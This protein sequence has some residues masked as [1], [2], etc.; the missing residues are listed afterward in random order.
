MR[1]GL[2]TFF[3]A[4]ASVCL[5]GIPNFVFAATMGSLAPHDASPSRNGLPSEQWI[6]DPGT[7]CIAADPTYDPGDSISWLGRCKQNGTIYGPGTLSFLYR[8][9]AVETVTGN[10]MDGLLQ[11]GHVLAAWSDGAKYEGDQ[12]GGLFNGEGKFVSAKGDTLE[13]QW[14]MGVLN[15]TASVVWAN[16]DRYDGAWKN[17]KSDGHGIETW[18]DGRR[19]E[20]E[21]RDGMPVS[22]PQANAMHA[23]S[24]AGPESTNPPIGKAVADSAAL[25]QTARQPAFRLA[26]MT[27]AVPRPLVTPGGSTKAEGAEAAGND[28]PNPAL[29]LRTHLGT[30]LVAVDSATL[31][32]ALSEGG[33]ERTVVLPSGNSQE[34]EFVF[35]KGPVGTVSDGEAAIGVFRAKADGLDID[36]ADGTTESIGEAAND[37]VLDRAHSPDGRVMCTAWYPQGHVFS[38]GEKQA[39]VQEYAT[40]LGVSVA[41]SAG[42]HKSHDPGPAC[43]GAFIASGSHQKSAAAA[44]RDKA[45][46][47]P[48]TEP[49]GSGQPAESADGGPA[50]RTGSA[51]GGIA[52]GTSPVHTIDAPGVGPAHLEQ[53]SFAPGV[54]FQATG[55]IHAGSNMPVAQPG[56]SD[57]LMITSNGEYWGFQN[58]CGKS[59]QF[60]YC[61]MSDANPLTACKRTSVS[62]SVASNGFSALVSD[63]SL[64]EKDTEHE[65]RWMACDGGAGEVVPHLDKVDPP[66]GRCE[67]AVAPA[68]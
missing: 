55:D 8:G 38:R 13:G 18:A 57:C 68:D 2:N 6:G 48:D 43:G 25:A 62:G 37:G 12:L 42:K 51:A 9:E 19:F 17:G 67:R 35:A 53:A 5:L 60:A 23:S 26:S 27:P 54:P 34:T 7:K 45:T 56:A 36:Y 49:G 11:P 64:A 65:F 61:E 31:E 20:G 4:A 14:K 15:G 41:A 50:K 66:S 33:F 46:A 47:A 22:N 1:S 40:R 58:R 21:W 39:A 16:G 29:P 63:R 28:A 32:L 59:V 52:V 30:Q 10:F 44:D 3:C 24:A